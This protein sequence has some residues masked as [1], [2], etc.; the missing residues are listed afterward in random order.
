ME[1]PRCNDT[2][3]CVAFRNKISVTTYKVVVLEMEALIIQKEQLII[4]KTLKNTKNTQESTQYRLRKNRLEVQ[5][6][7]RHH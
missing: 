3:T 7:L 6:N 4:Q 5:Y 1:K 2:D